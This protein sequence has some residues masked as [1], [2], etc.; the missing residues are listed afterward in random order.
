MRTLNRGYNAVRI[1]ANAVNIVQMW[2][3]I[4]CACLSFTVL[5]YCNDFRNAV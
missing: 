4:K 1:V 3:K 2:L 5:V